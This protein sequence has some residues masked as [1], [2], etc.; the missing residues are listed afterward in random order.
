V[1]ITNVTNTVTRRQADPFGAPRNAAAGMDHE[2]APGGGWVGDRG[3]LDKTADSTGLTS[4]GARFYDSLLGGFVSVDPVMDLSDPQQWHAYG[5]ANNNPTTWSDPTGLLFSECHDGS[6]SCQVSSSGNISADRNW[7]R[8]ERG[9]TSCVRNVAG[10][11]GAP[12]KTRVCYTWYACNFFATH[13]DGYTTS[14]GGTLSL[15]SGRQGSL[16]SRV[17]H[18]GAAAIAQAAEKK[19]AAEYK[20]QQ[21]KR[22]QKNGRKSVQDWANNDSDWWGGQNVAAGLGIVGMVVG[23]IG[24]AAGI[25]GLTAVAGVPLLVI[26]GVGLAL[27]AAATAIDCTAAVDVSCGIG[28]VGTSLG[29]GG[30][31][32][33]ALA[34]RFATAGASSHAVDNAANVGLNLDFHS[35]N[36]TTGSTALSFGSR[37][38]EYD[39]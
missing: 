34:G 4:V 9:A 37:S 36:L 38:F 19:R 10:A 22:D 11:G 14:G 3:F 31:G 28:V 15:V 32:A 8:C 33:A 39:W 21:E 30:L 13:A 24:L 20:A 12:V 26:A 18:Q 16:G 5:Y 7:D 2:S 17:S 25:A 1:Q 23:G 35:L 27:G 29:M 6:H